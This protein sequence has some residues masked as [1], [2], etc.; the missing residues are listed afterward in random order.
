[1]NTA[2]GKAE[3]GDLDGLVKCEDIQGVL[4]D[5]MSRELG[6]ARSVLVREHLRK[7]EECQAAAKDVQTTL[8]LLHSLSRAEGDADSRLTDDRRRRVL[9]ALT[10][11]VIHWVERHHILVS[12]VATVLVLLVVLTVLRR[13]R[14]WRDDE[15]QPGPVIMIGTNMPPTTNAV[16]TADVP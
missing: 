12:F 14:L 2:E 8:D 5:Y 13:V 1:M 6:E 9:R 10:H 7:C 11:P 3:T 4:F 16:S 15:Y